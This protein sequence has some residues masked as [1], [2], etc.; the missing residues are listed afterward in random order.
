VLYARSVPRGQTSYNTSRGISRSKLRDFFCFP[1]DF[2][3]EGTVILVVASGCAAFARFR[4]G[5]AFGILV[6]WLSTAP[7]AS[8]YCRR[9]YRVLITFNICIVMS[10]RCKLVIVHYFGELIR[11]S[12]GGVPIVR[13]N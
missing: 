4:L 6:C 5:E 10:I 7:R 8:Q 11:R 3:D 12:P 1:F 9:N 13:L 2:E